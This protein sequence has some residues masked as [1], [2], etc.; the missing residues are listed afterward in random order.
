[1]IDTDEKYQSEYVVGETEYKIKI[2]DHILDNIYG[3]IGLTDVENQIERLSIFKRL[4]NLSQLGLVKWIFPCALHTRYTHSIGVMHVAGKMA[5]HINI[6][7]KMSFFSDSEIQILRLAGLLHDIGHY[8]FSHN[9][10]RAY[11]DIQNAT[12]ENTD[13]VSKNIDKL[14]GC[15]YYLNPDY[16]F[17]HITDKEQLKDLKLEKE[18]IFQKKLSG[19]SGLHHESV[20]KEIIVNNKEIRDALMYNFVL[21]KQPRSGKY[22]LNPFFAP[23]KNG[24]KVDKVEYTEVEKI[25]SSLVSAIGNIVIGNYEYDVSVFPCLDK[26]SAMIQLIHSDMDADNID[27]LLRDATFS[28]TSYGTMDMSILLNSLYVTRFK[29]QYNSE[30][31]YIIGIS[32]KGIGAVEQFL[33]GK[34]MA[35]SQMIFSKYT[36]IL[37]AMM[38]RI[39]SE[40]IIFNDKIYERKK[41]LQMV[42][43]EYTDIKYLGFTD[44]YIFNKLYEMQDNINSMK[45]LPKSIVSRLTHSNAFDLY[46]K[47]ESENEYIYV[48]TCEKDIR[49]NFKKSDVYK[50]FTKTYSNLK[51]ISSDKLSEMDAAELFSYRFEEYSLIDEIPVDEFEKSFLFKDMTSE[52]RFNFWFYRLAKGIPIIEPQKEYRYEESDAGK[53]KHEYIPLLCVEHPRSMLKNLC[54]L[55]FVALRKYDISE[56][57]EVEKHRYK[58]ENKAIYSE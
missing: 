40:S 10:E 45:K 3:Q 46:S 26:Y 7:M 43:S 53:T 42:K 2:T 9:I 33:Y 19:S 39:A 49:L 57:A 6:N 5:T 25:V 32:K 17:E 31:K 12:V 27:Y 30:D 18:D 15:P 54:N 41:L 48:G 36:S 23:K 16:K 47:G 34:F 51:N 11:K 20:G 29:N 44:H 56:Y 50:M 21:I 1:M 4:H 13:E 22:V 28:G 14:T 58:N 55:K 37:E 52:R 35:Y 38:Y 24:K 8:P